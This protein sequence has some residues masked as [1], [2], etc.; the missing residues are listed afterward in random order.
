M[1]IDWNKLIAAAEYMTVAELD[2][3]KGEGFEIKESKGKVT[4]TVET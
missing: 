4:I 2:T 3:L 1:K